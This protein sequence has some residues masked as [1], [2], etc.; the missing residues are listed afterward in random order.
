M[1]PLNQTSTVEAVVPKPGP[2]QCMISDAPGLKSGPP[3]GPINYPPCEYY[4]EEL[5]E[6]YAKFEI[7]FTSRTR[8][9]PYKPTK[10]DFY[11]RTG[12]NE[13]DI[14]GYEFKDPGDD[15]VKLIIWDYTNGL[16]RT[17]GIFKCHKSWGKT[18]PARVLNKNRGLRD[19]SHKLT[20]GVIESQGYYMSFECA[21]AIAKKF[22]WHVRYALTPIFGHNFPGECLPPDHPGYGSWEIDQHIIREAAEEA[23]A[24][25]RA[26]LAH[27]RPYPSPSPHDDDNNDISSNGYPSS[28]D[29]DNRP[30]STASN[31]WTPVNTPRMQ[32]TPPPSPPTQNQSSPQSSQ[33]ERETGGWNLVHTALAGSLSYTSGAMDEDS[34]GTEEEST[35]G[36]SDD[37]RVTWP[38]IHQYTNRDFVAAQT[39]L[40]IRNGGPI[41]ENYPMVCPDCHAV[42]YIPDLRPAIAYSYGWHGGH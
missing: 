16:V 24:Y 12:R 26:A 19:V 20:G 7:C 35:D 6:I 40:E 25:R 14:Y 18:L 1:A 30:P 3:Q 8:R 10:P 33:G 28:S 9:I 22:C 34:D 23:R 39:M 31:G 15:Q 21:K 13:V 37:E 2:A 38:P 36:T 41:D 29:D 32:L 4:D 27:A 17:T 5:S 11:E 42:I